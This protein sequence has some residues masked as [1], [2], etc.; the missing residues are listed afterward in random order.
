MLT[1]RSINLDPDPVNEVRFH[2]AFVDEMDD[3]PL[4][5]ALLDEIQHDLAI[6]PL[7]LRRDAITKV[8]E[9]HGVS[10]YRYKPTTGRAIRILYAPHGNRRDVVM[11]IPRSSNYRKADLEAAIRRAAEWPRTHARSRICECLCN[12]R[13]PVHSA[14]RTKPLWT[15]VPGVGGLG[16]HR[17]S[18]SLDLDVRGRLRQQFCVNPCNPRPPV[19]R[20]RMHRRFELLRPITGEVAQQQQKAL[21]RRLRQV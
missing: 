4:A 21:R 2:S 7:H 20:P 15:V 19:L 16:F 6:S 14:R 5:E 17:T 12:P 8:K 3:H 18:Q 11:A 13:P 10:L 1:S 9:K